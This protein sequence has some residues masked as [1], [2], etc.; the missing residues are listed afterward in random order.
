MRTV[1]LMV[2]IKEFLIVFNPTA[3]FFLASI[4]GF[5]FRQTVAMSILVLFISATL[6][7]WQFRVAFALLGVAALF[8]LGLIDLRNFIFFAQLD[9]IVF[10]VGMM[11]VIGI[12][13]ERHFFDYLLD[14]IGSRI[15]SG[16]V[17]YAMV[18][19]MAAFMAALVDE[20]TSIIFITLFIVKIA[21]RLKM[22]PV[23]L[24]LAAVFTT[25]VGSSATVVGN[26]IGVIVALRGGFTFTDFLTWAAPN[27]LLVLLASIVASLVLWRD[28]VAEMNAK[29][30]KAGIRLEIS[31]EIRKLQLVNWLL[32]LGTIGMLILHHPLEEQLEVLLGKEKGSM[33]NVLLVATPMLWSG[34]GLLLERHRAREIVTQRVDWWTLLFFLLL[35]ST[36]GTLK[37]TGASVKMGEY[38]V[39]LGSLVGNA[40]GS[41]ETGTL[42][43]VFAAQGVLTAFLDNVLAI[44]VLIPVVFSL[45]ESK[46]WNVF[47]MFWA[48]LFSGTMAGNYTPIGSTANI[49]ALGLMEKKGKKISFGYWIKYAIPI[50]T[51]QVLISLLWLNLVIEP[52]APADYKPPP[53]ATE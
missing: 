49:I 31:D 51:L 32:F 23:P 40:V 44:A 25:N 20:V 42:L 48:L 41:V 14:T 21:D 9:V 7:Y 2:G 1:L 24:V 46:G 22:D 17:L 13:E 4:G 37:Y 53:L 47:A 27:A 30:G 6:L 10:L 52:R 12:L 39:S 38:I 3:M 16:A 5:D 8:F 29:V 43:T 35:F 26:P 45:Y 18:L 50:A 36:V 19:F 33:K 28:Y 34:I 15:R 11:T